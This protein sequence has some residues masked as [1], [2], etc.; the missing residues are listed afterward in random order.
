M[1]AYNDE[2]RARIEA[3]SEKLAA[4]KSLAAEVLEAWSAL[5]DVDASSGQLEQAVGLLGEVEGDLDRAAD[6]W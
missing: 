6:D 1:A 5:P 2:E 4:A 3:A